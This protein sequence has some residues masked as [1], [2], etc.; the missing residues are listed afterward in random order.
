MPNGYT[1][2]IFM[3]GIS[4]YFIFSWGK[5]IFFLASP[6]CCSVVA[7]DHLV[8]N[9]SC[10]YT[11]V[12]LTTVTVIFLFSSFLPWI[13]FHNVCRGRQHLTQIP[14]CYC[15]LQAGITQWAKM[16]KP[17]SSLRALLYNVPMNQPIKNL[18]VTTRFT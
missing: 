8:K 16:G 15:L 1:F 4:F 2:F 11:C 7:T 10:Y 6:V 18:R 3:G 17:G 5:M 9:S 13:R 12:K 14:F